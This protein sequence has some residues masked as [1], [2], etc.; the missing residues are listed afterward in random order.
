[1]KVARGKIFYSSNYI[2]TKCMSPL[3][4]YFYVIMSRTHRQEARRFSLSVV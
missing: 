2:P 3:Y 4:M 1:M